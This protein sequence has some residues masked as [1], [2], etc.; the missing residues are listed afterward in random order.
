LWRRPTFHGQYGPRHDWKC[1]RETFGFRILFSSYQT[2]YFAVGT[3]CVYVKMSTGNEVHV[4][5]PLFLFKG[6]RCRCREGIVPLIIKLC[7][8]WRR[9]VNSTFQPLHLRKEPQYRLSR[10]LR[11]PPNRPG[12][13]G[14]DKNLLPLPG[15][16]PP[17]FQPV[18]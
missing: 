4:L 18:V 5:E 2:R 3:F 12:H 8:R 1:H 17:A 11:W 14:K 7:C 13:L 15:L 6:F 9:V 16:E 10:R